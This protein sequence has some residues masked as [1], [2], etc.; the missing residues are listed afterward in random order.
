MARTLANDNVNDWLADNVLLCNQIAI[1][2]G[3]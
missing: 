3:V 1:R 2:I